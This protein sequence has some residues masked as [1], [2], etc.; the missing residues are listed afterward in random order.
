MTLDQDDSPASTTD[1][2]ASS[3]FSFST[4][5]I[6]ERDRL[7]FFK[8]EISK[9]HA[10][11]VQPLDKRPKH[12]MHVFHAGPVAFSEAHMSPVRFERR[13]DHLR[14]CDDGLVFFLMTEGGQ[15][16]AHNGNEIAL[17]A[18]N[19]ALV[20]NGRPGVGFWP[21]G[22]ATFAARVDTTVLRALV[23]HPEARAGTL[24]DRAQPGLALLEGYVRSFLKLRDAVTPQL[25]QSFGHH[26]VDLVATV[27][28]PTR[29]G[30][31]QAE[32]G[33]I[34]AARLRQVLDAIASR[35]CDPAFGV[36]T[37]AGE[38]G[39]SARYI[40]RILETTGST[41]TE[42]VV[43]RRLHRARHLL[44]HALARSKVAEIALEAGFNDLA[45]FHRVFRR[46]FGETPAAMRGTN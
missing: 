18:G 13:R 39:V 4:D 10:I 37:V 2:P 5:W 7:D 28:G 27:L 40:Q 33:G 34:R 32:G 17:E 3:S 11:E 44:G 6:P 9:F 46:R 12:V 22:G 36:E 21:K 16:L 35:A 38:L 15:R 42:H 24:I 8:G 45:H 31:A 41:F 25:A 26:V 14:D 19:A 20:Y 43:E 1:V 30:A 29:D 23:K